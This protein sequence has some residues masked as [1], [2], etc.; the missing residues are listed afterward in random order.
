MWRWVGPHATASCRNPNS[1]PCLMLGPC[2]TSRDLSSI[3]PNVAA[4]DLSINRFSGPL[5][6]E[7]GGHSK[8]TYL[9]LT[10][11]DMSGNFPNDWC[12]LTETLNRVYLDSNPKLCG[13]VPYCFYRY[14]SRAVMIEETG[15]Y[16]EGTRMGTLSDAQGH[17]DATP[18]RC[19]V[20]EGCR[21]RVKPSQSSIGVVE[22]NTSGFDE[23]ESGIRR[24][25][26]RVEWISGQDRREPPQPIGRFSQFWPAT[27][28]AVEQQTVRVGGDVTGGAIVTADAPPAVPAPA[29]AP[30]RG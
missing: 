29:P 12:N 30:G 9:G 18:P 20:A 4:L 17:C 19:T 25:E 26:W 5:P 15:M 8:L 6:P 10:L 14:S 1:W 23:H 22:F 2:G 24:Y 28:G 21:V 3:M 16:K 27:L 13:E 7:W 11:N